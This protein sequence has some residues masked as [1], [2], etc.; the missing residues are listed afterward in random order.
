MLTRRSMLLG[1]AGAAIAQPLWSAEPVLPI[2]ETRFG[3]VMGVMDGPIAQFRGIPYGAPTGGA[4]RFMPPLKPQPWAGVRECLGFTTLCPQAGLRAMDFRSEYFQLIGW[5]QSAGVMSEDCLNLNVWTPGLRDG[6]P[7]PVFVS[8]H[9]GNFDRGTANSP[10]YDGKNLALLGDVVVVTV[11]HRLASLGYLHL[12]D[13]GV[14]EEFASAGAVGALDMVA[15]LAW[16]RDNIREFGGDPSRVTIVGQSGGGAKVATLLA[17]PAARGLFHRAIIQSG[18]RLRLASREAA[19]ANTE[20]LLSTLGLR[21]S[22]IRALQ[23]VPW[24]RLIEAQWQLGMTDF[25]PVVGIEALPRH[26]FDSEQP[27]PS[28]DVPL[29]MA[30]TL[31]D[32]AMFNTNFDLDEAGLLEVIQSRYPD[33]AREILALYR[34]QAPRKTPF[35]I[36]AQMLS[37]LNYRKPLLTQ[38]ELR[39]RRGGAPVYSYLWRWPSPAYDGKFGAVHFV[40][41]PATFNNARDA[42]VGGG[43]A[44]GRRLCHQLASACIEFAR[45]GKPQ[46]PGGLS[47]LP[48]ETTRRKVAVFDEQLAVDDDP[49]G[50]IRRFWER[51]SMTGDSRR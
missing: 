32:A 21:A 46:L 11:N 4:N 16:V 41:V 5:D 29:M 18:G 33:Q 34:D 1:V 15:A 48:F 2:A 6:T 17:M 49:R 27:A 22:N 8:F 42:I 19:T 44:V 50:E 43:S 31:E 7:R 26:Y 39:V 51:P 25:A 47:W 37:D 40:D 3:K 10:G 23:R 45:S 9:G 12:A 14:P 30:S 36:Q 28:D 13:L 35:L 20:K 24:Q 38:A